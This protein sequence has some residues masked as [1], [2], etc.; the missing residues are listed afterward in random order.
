MANKSTKESN[1]RICADAYW[2]GAQDD[3]TVSDIIN[4][5]E[6]YLK[7]L[8]EHPEKMSERS[9]NKIINAYISG[10]ICENK[11]LRKNSK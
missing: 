11:M 1:N 4:T 5:A 8:V 3:C 7:R 2:A 9:R 10:L 6:H